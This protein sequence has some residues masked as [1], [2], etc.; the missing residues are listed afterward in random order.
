M[1]KTFACIALLLAVGLA[2]ASCSKTPTNG[3][4]SSLSHPKVRAFISNP[5][6][7]S[8][9]GGFSQVLNIVDATL[10]EISFSVVNL[11]GTSAVPGLMALS[12]NKQ[13]L[14][15]FSSSDN[16]IAV[17]DTT[18]QAPVTTGSTIPLAGATQSMLV[19]TD[20][21]TGYAAVPTASV[22]TPP[23]SPGLVEVFSLSSGAV[24][25]KIPVPGVS[26][27]AASHNGNRI[28]GLGTDTCLDGTNSVTVIAPSLIGTS[29]DPRT[30]VCGFDHP[31][32]AAFSSD[33]T[34]AYVLNCGP[35][36]GGS[37]AGVTRLNLNTN[38]AD[39]TVPL[40]AAGATVGLLTGNTLYVA[41]TPPGTACGSGTAALTCGT[42]ATVDVATM[43][44]TAA[45]ALI[46]DGRHSRM[47]MGANGQ[48]FIG[49]TGCT[50]VNTAGE[51]R[52]CLSI[53]DTNKA[54]VV[55]PPD[56]GDVTGI[57]PIANRSVVYVCQNFNFRVY[58]TTTD[59]LEVI[60]PASNAA[61]FVGQAI[62]VKLID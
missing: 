42:V 17:V 44:V 53:F 15:I 36:C 54:T 5:L 40:P 31:V 11:S 41:G 27:V 38:T 49:A 3:T 24:G 25:A 22:T 56:A 19:S 18:T 23:S 34:A 21:A 43:S 51:V 1:K 8:G 55:I 47:E 37:V 35:E 60:P 4:S 46:T 48:L 7:P 12:P 26:F 30:V 61:I 14:L 32:W 50:S 52:G 57:Q 28:L 6:Y 16:S 33:D 2:L 59:K 45:P 13:R 58:D 9:T 10:D 29:Q 39:A 20:N 62:D